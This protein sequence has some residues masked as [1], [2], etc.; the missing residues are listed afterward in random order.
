MHVSNLNIVLLF[1]W[2]FGGSANLN[3]KNFAGATLIKVFIIADC[4]NHSNDIFWSYPRRN[5]L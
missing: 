5:V 3:R 2:G 1:M 4:V